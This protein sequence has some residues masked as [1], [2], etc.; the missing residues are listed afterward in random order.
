MNRY[1]LMGY[2]KIW[3][4]LWAAY[5]GFTA[6]LEWLNLLFGAV[7]A[8][9]ILLLIRPRVAAL[10]LRQLVYSIATLL[11]Y[12]LIVAW[13][14]LKNGVVVARIVLTP[15]LPI[16]PGVIAIPSGTDSR[17]AQAFSA[18][19]IT[20]TPGEFVLE[21]DQQG[22]LY[23]HSLDMDRTEPIAEQEQARRIRWLERIVST[24][25]PRPPEVPNTAGRH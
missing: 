19:S 3:L 21:M 4:P 22:T 7:L 13:E 25:H 16:K 2:L 9:G 18:H 23:V 14:V 12:V 17:I 11:L 6:N 20:I 5:L 10:T 24:D 8:L 15:S 1:I